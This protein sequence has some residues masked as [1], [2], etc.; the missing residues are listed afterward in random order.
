MA[1]KSS[2]TSLDDTRALVDEF[3]L[4]EPN[5]SVRR[6]AM[7]LGIAKSTL[8][9]I[10]KNLKLTA[11]KIQVNQHLTEDH[12]EKRLAFAVEKLEKF[13]QN[14]IHEDKIWFDDEAYFSLDS[15]LNKQILLLRA[16]KT[17]NLPSEE[18]L[19]SKNSCFGSDFSA[20]TRKTLFPRW[21]SH[22]RTV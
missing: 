10:M 2:K 17:W 6:A 16:T 19:S 13:N 4:K 14:Q 8:F 12:E 18:A 11:Y 5:E 15:H 7:R 9:D 1:T 21:I 3:F 20:W 22:C